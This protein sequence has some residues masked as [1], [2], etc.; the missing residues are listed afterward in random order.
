MIQVHSTSSRNKLLIPAHGHGR[1]LL[2]RLQQV[3]TQTEQIIKENAHTCNFT[4]GPQV[5]HFEKVFADYLGVPHAVAFN[6]GSSAFLAL[7]E[8]MHFPKG[9][10]I[11][12]P[13]LTFIM[14][15]YPISSVGLVPVFV[16]ID[17]DTYT[18]DPEQV[19]QAIT[20]KTVAI[21]PVHLFGQ[22][23]D[24]DPL[25]VL[26]QE[27]NL[28]VFEDASQ[29]HGATYKG[30]KVGGLGDAS[31]FSLNAVKNMGTGGGDAGIAVLSQNLLNSFP[32][33][34]SRLK[35][36][37][38]TGRTGAE[39][40]IH[41]EYGTRTRMNEYDAF[42]CIEELKLLN[43]WNM[44]RRQIAMRYDGA[45]TGTEYQSPFFSPSDEHAYFHYMAK[46]ANV[47]L[48]DQLEKRLQQAG[49]EVGQR[50][51]VVPDQRMYRVG[52]LASRT[53]SAEYARSVAGLLTPVP[54]YPELSDAEVELIAEV[55]SAREEDSTHLDAKHMPY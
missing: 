44:R 24:L 30:K 50:Y 3:L 5:K 26:A 20:E 40:Y 15:C 14:S 46:S 51:T 28:L 31:F 10:E 2:N 9:S 21:L 53:F 13:A 23:A 17:P 19:A 39:R 29:A 32:H 49:I 47:L 18:M 45:L 25:L 38:D 1:R 42:E 54:I 22:S 4:N 7:L 55:L 37:R 34:E 16:D 33:F 48:R 41:D 8:C 12:C 52:E 11:I 27:H 35:A 6:S 36:W 43:A